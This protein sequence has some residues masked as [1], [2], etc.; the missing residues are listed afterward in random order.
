LV[1]EE[2][3][4]DLEV[5]NEERTGVETLELS[6]AGEGKTLPIILQGSHTRAKLLSSSIAQGT[7]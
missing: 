3:N 1:E 2:V 6:G 5:A 4:E 7:P